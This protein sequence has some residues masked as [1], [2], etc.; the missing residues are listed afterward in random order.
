[1]H[2]PSDDKPTQ[3]MLIFPLMETIDELGG[4]A[5]A[6]TVAD[7][8]ADRFGLTPEVREEFTTDRRGRKTLV[9]DRHVRWAALKGMKSEYLQSTGYGRWGLTDEG[10]EGTRTAEPVLRVRF[11]PTDDPDQPIEAVF[12]LDAAVPTV[13]RIREGDA[14][15]L[16][17]VDDESVHLVVTSMPYFDLIN[18]EG[19]GAAN[20]GNG[21]GH[22]RDDY[23]A[24][25]E[26]IDPVWQEIM[27]VLSPGGNAVINVADVARKKGAHG[28]SELYPLSSHVRARAFDLGFKVQNAP[29]WLKMGHAAG[30]VLGG[31]PKTDPDTGEVSMLPNGVIPLEVEHLIRLRKP[32]RRKLSPMAKSMSRL[33][34]GEY[35]KLFRQTWTDLPGADGRG[36]KPGPFEAE[37]HHPA[38]FPEALATRLIRML[39]YVGDNVADPFGGEFNVALAAMKNGRSSVSSDISRPYVLA[40]INYVRDRAESLAA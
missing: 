24:F 12:E 10:S 29:Y 2:P 15:D 25:L 1:M 19:G 36:G 23:Y 33:A 28:S 38:V 37:P 32:G 30:R 4:D 6:K 14:R 11:T 5:K 27:R 9:W 26:R 40:G 17:W 21:W 35:L 22:G 39:S 7:A 34:K 31:C 18:Y 16:H 13:H 3:Q 8:L 20:L